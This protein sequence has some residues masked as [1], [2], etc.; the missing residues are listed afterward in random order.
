[1]LEIKTVLL[2]AV[3]VAGVL[4]GAWPLRQRQRARG[5]RGLAWGNAFAAGVFLGAGLLHLLPDANE[6][7]AAL[8]WG[9]PIGY[10]LAALAVLGM[11][12][13]E[14]VLPPEAA[15]HAIHAPSTE[16]FAGREAIGGR[17]TAYAILLALG[18]H[19]FLAGLAL[20]A[21]A[22]LSR[23]LVLFGAI[24]AH[25]SVA[26]FALGVSLARSGL[27]QRRAWWLLWSFALA[28]PIG[29]AVGTGF[30]SGLDGPLRL[31]A[32]AS[33]LALAAG[34]FVYVATLD[35]L[36]EE[37]HPASDRLAKWVWVGAGVAIM[38]VLALW[39]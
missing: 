12:W 24:L 13:V 16:R 33:F 35:I 15:H 20:G 32:E 5:G 9:Y 2:L 17:R 39:V 10:A 22:E 27:S 18:I 11:W 25:K 6:A 1:M 26:G 37:A 19:S 36:R 4:G 31:G 8:G 7:W 34:T 21:Q 28:T 30:S 38:A 3:L 29:I 14:H 23:A